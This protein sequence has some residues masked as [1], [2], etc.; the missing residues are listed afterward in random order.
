MRAICP[1]CHHEFDFNSKEA[2]LQFLRK[3]G[4]SRNIEVARGTKISKANT[5]VLLNQLASHDFVKI[6]EF[7]GIKLYNLG[8]DSRSW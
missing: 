3:N 4:K 5:L 7:H 1:K 8:E 6:E 2:I